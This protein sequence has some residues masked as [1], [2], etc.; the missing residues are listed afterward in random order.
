MIS[1][2]RR[3]LDVHDGQYWVQINDAWWP[4]PD[5]SI[6]REGNRIGRPVVWYRM[7]RSVLHADAM[8]PIIRCFLPGALF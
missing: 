2:L 8:V 5:A 7:S 1:A 4:V 6:V 3:W